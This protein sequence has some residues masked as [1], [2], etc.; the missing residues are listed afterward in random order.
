M[1]AGRKFFFKTVKE[2]QRAS[3]ENNLPYFTLKAQFALEATVPPPGL[4]AALMRSNRCGPGFCNL[5]AW[6]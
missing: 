5:P 4:R 1:N 3:V 2:N 6:L